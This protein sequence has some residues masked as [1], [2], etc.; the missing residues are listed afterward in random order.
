[1][2]AETR[3]SGLPFV[4]VLIAAVT[5]A[6]FCFISGSAM[7]EAVLELTRLT[8]R[9]SVL[10]FIAA[11]AASALFALWQS[12]L[13]R[14]LLQNRRNI[15]LAF[16]LAH[17]IHLGVLVAHFA[18]SGKDPGLARII[19]GGLGY[20]LIALMAATSNDWSVRRL[21]RNWNRLHTVGG[22]YV[23][24]IFVNSYLGRVMEG[25]EPV[26]LF[27]SIT[28]LLVIVA[29]LKIGARLRRQS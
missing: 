13:T 15:G 23:W 28:G 17:F 9:L 19:G 7:E 3:K 2:M 20:V 22:W 5:S 26:F 6:V 12:G 24:L 29:V 1:M 25:R 18:V 21:G 11:F 14:A 27:G 16:A 8:A 10:F 4:L